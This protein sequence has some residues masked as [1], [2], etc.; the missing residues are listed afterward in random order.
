M[1]KV[2]FKCTLP[3]RCC[4]IQKRKHFMHRQRS[5]D[6][7]WRQTYLSTS[8]LPVMI[9]LLLPYIFLEKSFCGGTCTMACFWQEKVIRTVIFLFSASQ[10]N[11]RPCKIAQWP[12]NRQTLFKL[13]VNRVSM[14]DCRNILPLPF[15]KCHQRTPSWICQPICLQLCPHSLYPV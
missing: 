3:V 6:P 5:S 9:I 7:N 2:F 11:L 1:Q 13:P 4:C 14:G 8:G 12:T 15:T 10:A